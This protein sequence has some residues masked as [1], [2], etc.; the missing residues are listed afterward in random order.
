MSVPARAC[1][2]WPSFSRLTSVIRMSTIPGVPPSTSLRTHTGDFFHQFFLLSDRGLHHFNVARRAWGCP[3]AKN[4]HKGRP[5]RLWHLSNTIASR[6]AS[7]R[8]PADAAL[9][10]PIAAAIV[11]GRCVT[12]WS[13][14]TSSL[15]PR[16]LRRSRS[17][18]VITGGGRSV[19]RRKG[20]FI[21]GDGPS[22]AVECRSC[23]CFRPL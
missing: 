20:V 12:P 19:Q 5:M 8:T 2:P 22:A 21:Q 1:R 4:D 11:R 6:C 16:R 17:C 9:A 15:S 10:P 7:A 3:Q 13:S 14:C 18:W 23:R